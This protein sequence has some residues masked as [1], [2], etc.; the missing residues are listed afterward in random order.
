MIPKKTRLQ[1]NSNLLSNSNLYKQ[2]NLSSLIKSGQFYIDQFGFL[3]TSNGKRYP[4]SS[5]PPEGR[6]S[7]QLN[8]LSM[9]SDSNNN[10]EK[11]I[12]NQNSPIKIN[13]QSNQLLHN[14][15][16]IIQSILLPYIDAT[17]LSNLSIKQLRNQNQNHSMNLIHFNDTLYTM[18]WN[19]IL[20]T[21][22]IS[23]ITLVCHIILIIFL[24]WRL[25]HHQKWLYQYKHY[26]NKNERLTTNSNYK[27]VLCNHCEA[28]Q[29]IP[30]KCITNCPYVHKQIK[31]NHNNTTSA[32][33]SSSSSS[34]SSTSSSSG[35]TTSNHNSSNI[36]DYNTQTLPHTC[37]HTTYNTDLHSH[38]YHNPKRKGRKKPPIKHYHKHHVN[39][40]IFSC[41]NQYK[42]LPY[43]KHSL[44]LC[45]TNQ[46]LDM[47]SFNEINSDSSHEHDN[48]HNNHH[49]NKYI[50]NPTILYT[51]TNYLKQ[52]H[53]CI[54]LKTKSNQNQLLNDCFHCQTTYKTTDI[55]DQ[56]EH[57]KDQD[58]E[59][60]KEHLPS[61][62]KYILFKNS[63]HIYYQHLY[64]CYTLAIH[65]SLLNI[66]LS[67]FQLLV[68]CIGLIEKMNYPN[69]ITIH[70]EFL[71]FLTHSLASYT[72]LC[73][74]LYLFII[75]ISSIFITFY[76]QF[77]IKI[78]ITIMD[79]KKIQLP[80]IFLYKQFL[81]TNTTYKTTYNHLSNTNTTTT[82]TTT[83]NTTYN[84]NESSNQNHIYFQQNFVY[85]TLVHSIPWALAAGTSLLITFLFQTNYNYDNNNNSII[86]NNQSIIM[87][88]NVNILFDGL[89]SLLTCSM[90]RT[91]TTPPSSSSSASAS[92]LTP[93]SCLSNHN[94]NNN[95]NNRLLNR[96]IN[97]IQSVTMPYFSN[98]NSLVTISSVNDK[99]NSNS[100]LLPITSNNIIDHSIHN[101][102]SNEKHHLFPIKDS[103][104][105]TIAT[106]VNNHNSNSPLI[107]RN[108]PDA[109]PQ[110]CQ[111]HQH[112]L[113]QQYEQQQQHQQQQQ[114]PQQQPQSPLITI[115]DTMK[116]NRNFTNVP[117]FKQT[118]T[119]TTNFNE[120]F[121]NKSITDSFNQ[122]SLQIINNN[123]D[124]NDT[125]PSLINE[126]INSQQYRTIT[127][128]STATAVVM[129]AAAAA[130]AA[131]A[132][133]LTK[134]NNPL[135]TSMIL[136]TSNSL[137]FINEPKTIEQT[138]LDD[139]NCELLT[140]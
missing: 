134:T 126:P 127:G 95:N 26:N 120:L 38:M 128:Q 61:Y 82:T 116:R 99:I 135:N 70:I 54:H 92:V 23:T 24:S 67:C 42:S 72:I 58:E 117:R 31:G 10:H 130:I 104:L 68:V 102:Y 81:S 27:D 62:S 136:D 66:L 87:K 57:E 112:L 133:T 9:I 50:S 14:N 111:H 106:N 15:H 96:N 52:Q 86:N 138:N 44:L 98:S 47:D 79:H 48:Q 139:I 29:F 131:Q 125:T 33:T 114:Q 25:H 118:I 74:R 119:P 1:L 83:N 28:S 140:K 73:V 91:T 77:I 107:Y 7:L 88:R 6:K 34:S 16:T 20:F 89:N 3:V 37:C 49:S 122:S 21:I 4:L 8:Q 60:V 80:K 53:Q 123:N 132:S 71:C 45:S 18:N 51:P 108:I 105:V 137:L 32:T 85:L 97:E 109:L 113:A 115:T 2:S 39:Q 110:L 75:F 12:I 69:S 94:N 56:E 100:F 5:G 101:I 90:E 84:H 46:Q 93:P 59:V 36:M 78:I 35:S 65:L 41:N 30:C 55:E 103:Q 64:I 43:Y 124:H 40:H 76:I 11:S 13:N 19:I 129:A 121:M 22:I 63:I 17:N